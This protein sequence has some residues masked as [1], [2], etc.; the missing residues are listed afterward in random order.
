MSLDDG[1]QLSPFGAEASKLEVVAGS[2]GKPL[3]QFSCSLGSFNCLVWISC[4]Q[5]SRF[6]TQTGQ[7]LD[8]EDDIFLFSSLPELCVVNRPAMVGLF[9]EHGRDN[10]T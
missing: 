2:D 9:G 10:S 8:G 5:K 1:P 4:H 3:P 6:K 7:I